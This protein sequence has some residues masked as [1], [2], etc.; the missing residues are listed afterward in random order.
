MFVCFELIL[1]CAF[2]YLSPVWSMFVVPQLM[3][4]GYSLSQ[5]GISNTAGP[6]PGTK[7]T[8]H[9]NSM[10]LLIIVTWPTLICGMHG[11]W[12]VVGT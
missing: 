12:I 1:F 3:L 5:S 9:Q 10:P 11:L 8:L 6:L 4:G 2:I 7:K